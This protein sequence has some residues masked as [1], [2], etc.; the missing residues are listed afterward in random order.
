MLGALKAAHEAIKIQCAAQIELMEKVGKAK[1]EYC[2]EVNDENI[3]QEVQD[4]CYQAC[5]DF[6]ISGCADKHLREDTFKGILD[7]YLEKYTEEEL[8]TVAPLAKR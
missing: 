6:S 3:R 2:H 1:R 7:K 8:E 4:S 5:Y